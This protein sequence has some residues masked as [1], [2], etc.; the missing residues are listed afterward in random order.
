MNEDEI[1][2]LALVVDE[3]VLNFLRTAAVGVRILIAAH[4]RRWNSTAHKLLILKQNS[5]HNSKISR[6]EIP[7]FNRSKCIS[8]CE[9]DPMF[10]VQRA[11]DLICPIV[12][13]LANMMTPSTYIKRRSFNYRN[14]NKTRQTR[15]KCK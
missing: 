8:A 10:P 14:Y 15:I 4:K 1:S 3:F 7:P 9:P 11:L 13:P 5:W 6:R 2:R 12:Y